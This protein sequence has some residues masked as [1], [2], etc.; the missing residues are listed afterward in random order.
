MDPLE[1]ELARLGARVAPQWLAACVNFLQGSQPGFGGASLPVQAKAVLQQLLA[2]DLNQC[3]APALPP[4][5]QVRPA[6]LTGF[7]TAD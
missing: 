3:G 5:A 6:R 7:F 4:G 1:D 2:A